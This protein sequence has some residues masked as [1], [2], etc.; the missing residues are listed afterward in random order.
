MTVGKLIELLSEWEDDVEVQLATRGGVYE[1]EDVDLPDDSGACDC[2]C[3]FESNL[4]VYVV[5]EGTY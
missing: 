4:V 2:G 3:Q 1:I 5:A